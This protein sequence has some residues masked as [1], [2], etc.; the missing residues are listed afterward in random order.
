[1]GLNM[2]SFRNRAIWSG[3]FQ[4]M[5]PCIFNKVIANKLGICFLL[6]LYGGIING[7]FKPGDENDRSFVERINQISREMPGGDSFK[8]LRVS[9]EDAGKNCPLCQL[10]CSCLGPNCLGNSGMLKIR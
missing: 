4:F 3:K 5:S 2:Y 1:M 10:K 9:R 8:D 7:N 6:G